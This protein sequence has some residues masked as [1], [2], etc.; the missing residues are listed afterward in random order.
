MLEKLNY[1]KI[2]VSLF[3]LVER[4]GEEDVFSYCEPKNALSYVRSNDHEKLNT[5]FSMVEFE[6][7]WLRFKDSYE[8]YK[9]GLRKCLKMGLTY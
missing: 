4:K 8:N 7:P 1:M 9:S 6:V 5:Q 3:S 2:L